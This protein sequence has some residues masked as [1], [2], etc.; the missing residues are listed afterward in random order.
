[1]VDASED[2]WLELTLEGV[3]VYANPAACLW[4]EQSFGELCGQTLESLLG[5]DARS[6]ARS[7]LPALGPGQSTGS[8]EGRW[9]VG[10]RY[11]EVR[12]K[13]FTRA[14]GPDAILTI[15]RDLTERHRCDLVSR[16]SQERLQLLMDKLPTGMLYEVLLEPS[17][18]RRVLF[19]SAGVA[20]LH[21]LTAEQ[22]YADANQLYGQVH[23]D[24]RAGLQEAEPRAIANHE[25]L[26]ASRSRSGPRRTPSGSGTWRRASPIRVRAGTRS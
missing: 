14:V 16:E 3:I 20:E 26:V 24:D 8:L 22:V 25:P 9:G 1:M 12:F 10:E 17:G 7:Y 13:R 15:A 11:V 6:S 18:H 21:G 4:S 19:V 23:E 2:A 5:A